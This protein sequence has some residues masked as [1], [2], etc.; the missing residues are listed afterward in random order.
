MKK[1]IIA[2][3]LLLVTVLPMSIFAEEDA[4]GNKVFQSDASITFDQGDGPV[5]PVD[6]IDP[7]EGENPGG[8]TGDHGPLSLD[9]VPLFSFQ[10]MKITGSKEISSLKTDIK[11][12]YI[13]VSDLRGEEL[14][15]Q[16]SAKLSNFTQDANP[17]K[18][19][20]NTS[21]RFETPSFTKKSDNTSEK[22]SFKGT[23]TFDEGKVGM[24]I[25]AGGSSVTMLEAAKGEGLGTWV[26]HW[27][28]PEGD[29][30]DKITFQTN[31]DKAQKGEYKATMDWTLVVTP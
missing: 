19:L 17:T 18:S 10:N 30:T 29:I 23:D 2:L 1:T 20:E 14:G 4:E 28:T 3:S 15:W 31:T 5:E 16:V 7:D 6:P 21:I 26:A 12:P 8:G 22:P 9:H 11:K 13:Q 24:V 27:L 25:S